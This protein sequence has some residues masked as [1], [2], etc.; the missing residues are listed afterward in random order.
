MTRG[1]PKDGSK[2]PGG[3]PI[4]SVKWTDESISELAQAL[5]T[6]ADRRTSCY[7][8]SFCAENKTYPQ[9]MSELAA[10]NESF[11][12]ALKRAKAACSSHIAEATAG[13]EMPPAFGIFALK[14][15]GWTDKQE[16]KHTGGITIQSTPID[17]AL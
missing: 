14:Q 5:I 2:N 16:L 3:R 9:K 12:E 6:W 4:G 10:Q 17:E 8:E 15:H 13:G 7:L 1:R 11:A